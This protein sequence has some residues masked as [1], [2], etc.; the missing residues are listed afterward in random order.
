MIPDIHKLEDRLEPIPSNVEFYEKLR[1][2]YDEWTN[3]LAGLGDKL[4]DLNQ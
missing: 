2:I 3:A 1:V 4:H